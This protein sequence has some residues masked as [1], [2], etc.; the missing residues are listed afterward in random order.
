MLDGSARSLVKWFRYSWVAAFP[1]TR[2]NPRAT[3]GEDSAK[4]SH[5]ERS[6]ATRENNERNRSGVIAQEPGVVVGEPGERVTGFSQEFLRVA[7][8]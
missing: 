3:Q 7:I 6:Q 1:L 2:T 4:P 5:K 8:D